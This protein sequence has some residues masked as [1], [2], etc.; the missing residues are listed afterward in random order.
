MANFMTNFLSLCGVFFL[1][2]TFAGTAHAQKAVLAAFN[3]KDPIALYGTE[4]QF[5]IMRSGKKIGDHLVRF[6]TN[7]D[8]IVVNSASRMQID[9]LF[10]TAFQYRYDSRAIWRDGILNKLEISV[11]DDGTLFS[12]LADQQGPRLRLTRGTDSLDMK[13]PI[14]PTNHWN[15][16]V[17]KQDQVLNTLTG[18]INNVLINAAGYEDVKTESGIIPAMRYTYT[19][20]LINEVWY[21]DM[22]RWVK[23]R[24]KGRDGSVIEY[25]CRQCQG[26]MTSQMAQ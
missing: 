13:L 12:M 15:A 10:F 23:L 26:G 2:L 25:V 11:N 20:D 7:D 4:M 22:G 8:K 24:F 6:D 3:A 9:I 5:D 19:G 16:E 21:D 1:S 17:L 18:E 14:Y